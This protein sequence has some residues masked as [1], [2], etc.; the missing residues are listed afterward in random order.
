MPQQYHSLPDTMYTDYRQPPPSYQDNYQ[1]M[2]SHSNF[3]HYRTTM[4]SSSVSDAGYDYSQQYY[5]QLQ[6]AN[7]YGMLPNYNSSSTTVFG[8]NFHTSPYS[9]NFHTPPYSSYENTSTSPTSVLNVKTDMDL[10]H[11]DQDGSIGNNGMKISPIQSSDRSESSFSSKLDVCEKSDVVLTELVENATNSEQ[12][13]ADLYQ[14]CAEENGSSKC[15][16]E[17]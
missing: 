8:N 6:S 2:Y 9:T 14:S 16:R 3:Q 7:S 1:L 10:D 11:N 5:P 4:A 12:N 13:N 17:I 15:M